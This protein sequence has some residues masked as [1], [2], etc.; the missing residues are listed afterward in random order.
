LNLTTRDWLTTLLVAAMV[1]LYGVYVVLGGVGP[2]WFG[3]QD[4][5][6]MA[7]V[8]I[9]VAAL[10]TLWGLRIT[11]HMTAWLRY[12]TISLRI[13]S[14]L[15]GLLALFGENVLSAAAWEGVLAAFMASIV[16][17]WG[18]TLS[19]HAGLLGQGEP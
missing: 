4:P 1:V 18:I 17:L 15:L 3:P 7:V 16:V 12:L 5:A 14:L 13:G 11:D 8:G 10:I 2:S 19:Q 6:G 9:G